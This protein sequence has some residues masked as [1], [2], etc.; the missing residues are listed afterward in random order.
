MEEEEEENDDSFMMMKTSGT[1]LWTACVGG[2]WV[3]ESTKRSNAQ[4][5]SPRDE[6]WCVVFGWLDRGGAAKN[7]ALSVD[8]KPSQSQAQLRARTSQRLGG[9][10]IAAASLSSS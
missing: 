4:C 2:G 5:R 7:K 6:S 1:F 8:N 3:D 9:V 10:D